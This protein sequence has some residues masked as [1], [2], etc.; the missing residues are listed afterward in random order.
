MTL[1]RSMLSG[2]SR[3]LVPL[4]GRLANP[5]AALLAGWAGATYGFGQV[6]TELGWI[7][8]GVSLIAGALFVARGDQ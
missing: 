7:V 6:A 8:G 3:L 4:I 5:D 2:A 1:Y